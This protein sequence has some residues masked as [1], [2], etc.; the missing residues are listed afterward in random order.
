MRPATRPQ[1]PAPPLPWMLHG[2]SLGLWKMAWKMRPLHGQQRQ[3]D[4][5]QRRQQRQARQQGDRDRDGERDAEVGVEGEAGRQQGQHGRDD[6]G[7]RER[8]RLADPGDRLDQRGPRGRAGPGQVGQ[9]GA[10]RP[11]PG[12]AVHAG[13]VMAG[14]AQFLPGPEDQ[15]QPVVGA[16]A[17]H[18]H[19]QQELGQRRYLEPVLGR[20]GHQRAGDEHREQRGQHRGDREG[21]RPEDEHQQDDDED[22]RQVLH[23]VAGVAGRLLLIHLDG[24]VAGQVRPQPGGQPRAANPRAQAVDQVLGVVL[25]AAV[26]LGQGQQLHRLAVGGLADVLDLADVRIGGDLVRH[27]GQ[28]GHVSRGQRPA[29]GRRDHRDRDQAGVAERR[30][31][32]NRVLARRAGRQELG[33][34]ALGHARQ[35]RQLRRGGDRAQDPDD[36]NQPA[37][38]HGP[39]ADAPENR[40][41]VHGQ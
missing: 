11:A 30:G 35:R 4:R 27:G 23:L 19:D 2:S 5:Q 34:V 28:R 32:V 6:G 20:L 7:G 26:V 24:R 9:H 40:I 17:Q 33:V 21:Q 10:H 14:V 12:P 16:R 38:T 22:Q 31:Q 15:E 39:P 18:Q 8:D 37:Q 29:R 13:H 1:M 41:D 36:E 3:P 25:V